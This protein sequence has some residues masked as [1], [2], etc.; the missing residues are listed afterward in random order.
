MK[1]VIVNFKYIF[2]DSSLLLDQRQYE[3]VSECLSG[4]VS[5]LQVQGPEFN[6]WYNKTHK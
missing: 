1:Y 4:R 3:G 2:L 5:A 6:S